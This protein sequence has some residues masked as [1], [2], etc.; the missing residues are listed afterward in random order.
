MYRYFVLVSKDDKK[1]F[2][3]IIPEF[4]TATES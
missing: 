2:E 4:T 1:I 3:F